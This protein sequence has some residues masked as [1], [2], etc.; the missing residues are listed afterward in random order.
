MSSRD[1]SAIQTPKETPSDYSRPDPRA[2]HNHVV[3]ELERIGL[4]YGFNVKG[5]A[6]AMKLPTRNK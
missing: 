4:E 6:N 2:A 1:L 3:H 5:F